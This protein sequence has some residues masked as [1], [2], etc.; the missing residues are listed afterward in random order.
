M[1]FSLLRGTYITDLHK[2]T[3]IGA[4]YG[5][6]IASERYD[7]ST[8]LVAPRGLL[9]FWDKE[10]IL[11]ATSFDILRYLTTS[12]E[13]LNSLSKSELID[14]SIAWATIQVYYAG[15]FAAHGILRILG[16]PVIYLEKGQIHI[17][18]KRAIECRHTFDTKFSKGLYSFEFNINSHSASFQNQG[19]GSHEDFWSCFTNAIKELIPSISTSLGS[20]TSKLELIDLF[21]KLEKLI[22]KPNWISRV[23]NNVNYRHEYE[24]W[25]PF[26]NYKGNGYKGVREDLLCKDLAKL[27]S[28]AQTGSEINRMVYSNLA[29]CF[30]F[31]SIVKDL[32][33]IQGGTGFLNAKNANSVLKYF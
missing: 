17:L 25:Y 6:W 20:D 31:I 12:V 11:S 13:T 4:G 8:N 1:D 29:I 18:Q 9:D 23:R 30:V 5:E 2:V 7:V 10:D 27:V 28:K 33:S 26:P 24:I 32:K 3:S 15:F 22:S 14:K 16:K 21:T 19:G